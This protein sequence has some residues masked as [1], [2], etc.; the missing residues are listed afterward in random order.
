[1]AA[2]SNRPP[3]PRNA[4]TAPTQPSMRAAV[5]SMPEPQRRRL[6]KLIEEVDLSATDPRRE[7]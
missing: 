1:M 5:P 4:H 2:P 6:G 7:D 3:S